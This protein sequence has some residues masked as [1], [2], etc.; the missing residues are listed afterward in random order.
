MKKSIK[1]LLQ[2]ALGPKAYCL[3]LPKGLVLLNFIIQRIIRIN[4]D[5]P[6]P[7]HYTS[8]VSG[9][10]NI[11]I[12]GDDHRSILVSLAVSG[13][14]Y[15]SIYPGTQ[16]QI[17]ERTLWAWGVTIITGNHGL[18]DR[19]DYS[20]GNITI[21]KNCWLG[22]KVTLLPGV[23]LGDN[24]TVGANSVVTKSFPSNVVIGGIPAKILRN[25]S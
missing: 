16:L 9:F 8:R 21:G 5:V 11:K 15:I 3:E 23:H 22:S 1:K 12:D 19:N 25:L 6:W 7:V 18:V 24:V 2:R 4:P 17:G 14:C 13:G 10:E 20:Y